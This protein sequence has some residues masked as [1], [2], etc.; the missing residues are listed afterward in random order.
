M[1]EEIKMIRSA[2]KDPSLRL[3]WWPSL[4]PLVNIPLSEIASGLDGQP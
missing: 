4:G 1:R 3:I 2:Q